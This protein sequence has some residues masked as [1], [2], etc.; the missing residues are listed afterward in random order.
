LKEEL[1]IGTA[2]AESATRATGA[3]PV[4]QRAGGGPIDIPLIVLNGR[5]DGPALWIDG[6]I[7]GD[8]HEGP[9]SI[10]RLVEQVDP[11]ALRGAVV[12]VPV[13]NVAAWENRWPPDG[14]HRPCAP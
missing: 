9:I 14:A 1:V 7:H 3:I 5:D 13:V 2:R 12:V 10:F 4:G 11:R 6:A 8:E